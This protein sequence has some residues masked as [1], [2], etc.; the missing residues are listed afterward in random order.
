MGNGARMQENKIGGLRSTSR[1]RRGS[2]CTGSGFGGGVGGCRR[3]LG[4]AAEIG[5]RE[6]I[7]AGEIE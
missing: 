5:C 4:T 6:V 2:G 1:S 3:W 7:G